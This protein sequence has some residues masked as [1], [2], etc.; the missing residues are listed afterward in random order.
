[1][2]S[3]LL[4]SKLRERLI[5]YVERPD[6]GSAWEEVACADSP[7]VILGGS[8]YYFAEM[9]RASFREGR[10]QLERSPTVGLRCCH[11]VQ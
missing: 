3:G 10:D 5:E 4:A 6:D 11:S 2:G 9:Q 1:V 8:W 7:R